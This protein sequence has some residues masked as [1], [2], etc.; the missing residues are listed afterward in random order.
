[1]EYTLKRI[2]RSASIRIRLNNEGQ[3]IVS[4]PLFVSRSQIDAYV[5]QTEPWIRRQQEKLKLKLMSYPNLNWEE[6]T[7]SYLGKLHPIRF[8]TTG[9][10][11]T[12][13]NG[14]F[15]INPVTGIETDAK[16]TLVQWLSYKSKLEI[17]NRVKYFGSI[18]RV[19]YNEV[20]FGQQTTR[21]GSCS[22]NNNLRFNWRLIHFPL[23][24]IDYVVIHE[25]SHTIHHNHSK[26]F[27]QLVEKY[28]PNWKTQRNFLKR[29]VVIKE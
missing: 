13:E 29:Q 19:K 20:R 22:G 4:S 28:C 17:L 25:L 18:M 24:V 5:R 12:I 26:N 16:R 11:V 9:D 10:K 3:V 7:V 2:A 23:E 27:W 21:W 1:M 15:W 8:R 14:V 6:G